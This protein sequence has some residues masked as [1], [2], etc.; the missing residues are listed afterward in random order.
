MFHF[1]ELFS[2]ESGKLS[3][4][5]E[6]FRRYYSIPETNFKVE[7]K[8]RVLE[9]IKEQFSDRNPELLDGV[10]VDLEKSWFNVKRC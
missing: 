9:K 6:Q 4:F 2:A 5:L 8:D 10:S 7:D 1:I 3:E